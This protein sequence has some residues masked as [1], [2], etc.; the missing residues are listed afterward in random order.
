MVQ[1]G[2]HRFFEPSERRLHS[3]DFSFGRAILTRFWRDF[4]AILCVPKTPSTPSWKSFWCGFAYYII[5][6]ATSPTLSP[7]FKFRRQSCSRVTETKIASVATTLES[8]T[9]MSYM[10]AFV[11]RYTT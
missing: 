10:K 4:D 7:V 5:H 3:K 2:M 1:Y 8:V 6:I 9:S 11:N